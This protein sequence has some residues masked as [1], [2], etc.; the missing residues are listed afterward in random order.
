MSHDVH[1][2]KRGD[3]HGGSSPGA[4]ARPGGTPGKQTLVEQVSA[5]VDPPPVIQQRAKGE[6]PA[7]EVHRA[8]EHGVA[9]PSAPLPFA[10]TI[11]HAFGRHDISTVQAHTGPEAANSAREMGAEA[12]AAGNHVVLGQRADLHTV[13]H[14]AAH[15][16]Q[17]RGGVQLKGGVGEVGDTYE[18]HADEVADAVVQ[19]RSAEALLDRHAPEGITGEPARGAVSGGAVQRFIN[20]SIDQDQFVSTQQTSTRPPGGLPQ[21][22]QGDHTTPFTSLQNQI[23][24]AIE[25]VS[26][27]DAWVNLADTLKVYQALPGWTE[28]K[29]WTTNTVGP[30]VEN[31]LNTKGDEVALQNAVT[32]MLA[33][34]NQIALT[35]LPSGGSGNAEGKWAGSLQHQERQFQLGHTPALP[36]D[37]VIEYIWKAF[38]HGR[39]NALSEDK[40]KSILQQHAMTMAD[41]YP[42]LNGSL[43]ITD[44]AILDYYPKRDWLTYTP[45]D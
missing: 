36:K 10:D 18:R 21:G 31:L 11:Q 41:A 34:R 33:L 7:P 17:Q 26:L 44:K 43:G 4:G 40:R 45:P 35:S 16:V 27:A 15:V 19:G 28:S 5:L 1:H 30:H 13:A 24:N 37:T 6:Q 29:K 23:A 9:T 39:V 8:A 32:Q 22:S 3:G 25:G 2:G 14:E 20:V 38:E 12:Y 42:Q